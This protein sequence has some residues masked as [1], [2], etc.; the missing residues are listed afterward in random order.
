MFNFFSFFFFFFYKWQ[1]NNN[2]ILKGNKEISNIKSL[3]NI[4]NNL[5]II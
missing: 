2:N 3:N 5:P 1:L 4:I